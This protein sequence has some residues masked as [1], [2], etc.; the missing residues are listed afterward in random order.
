MRLGFVLLLLGCF[1][2]VNGL[3]ILSDVNGVVEDG[4]LV[5]V[6]GV[7]FGVKMNVAPLM[8]DNFDQVG[9]QY[10]VGNK[11]DESGGWVAGDSINS[12]Y[13]N[14]EY[15]SEGART[16]STKYVRA[17]T[18]VQTLE[19]GVDSHCPFYYDAEMDL[20]KIY[21]TFWVRV[22]YDGYYYDVNCSPVDGGTGCG[23]VK[24]FRVVHAT[25]PF[26]GDLVPYVGSSFT[27]AT[28]TLGAGFSHKTGG[29]GS[30]GTQYHGL[31]TNSTWVRVEYI[32]RESSAPGGVFDGTEDGNMVV[33]YQ[34]GGEG[35]L[36]VDMVNRVGTTG[37]LGSLDHWRAVRFREY[38]RNGIVDIAFN[39][40]DIYIDNS[41]ARVE[42]GDN[43]D[44]E[45]CTHREVQV[46]TAWDDESVSFE[47]NQ[48]SFSDKEEV[49][50]FVVN[51]E[52]AASIGYPVTI[53]EFNSSVNSSNETCV[54]DWNCSEWLEC[55][56]GF[57]NRSCVDLGGCEVERNES[58]VCGEVE[59]C[60]AAD[61][62]VPCDGVQVDE[63]VA[64]L[65]EWSFGGV[66]MGEVLRVVGVWSEG[67]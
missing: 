65:E 54:E 10:E 9:T 7:G 40:D 14:P 56:E 15:Y 66:D 17:D 28:N 22:D 27:L 3:P 51:E 19:G 29:T 21:V 35:G 4:D 67:R 58:R 59:V 31:P 48:G 47:V 11:L 23:N 39:F 43:S 41:W 36:F 32:L 1:G 12:R 37:I 2:F 60:D 5:A 45:L 38:N 53:G 33:K 16:G 6:S 24:W 62:D 63:V 64:V 42:I 34:Q 20:N 8:W 18:P 52:G 46:V 25:N 30:V 50:V 57:E 61:K 13:Y 49:Y 44:F 55:I 26:Y